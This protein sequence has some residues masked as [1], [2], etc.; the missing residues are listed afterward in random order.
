M[1]DLYSV[2]PL[3][4]DVLARAAQ[5]TG[6]LVVVEDH[7]PEGGIGEAVLSALAAQ[8]LAPAFTHLAVRN[9]PGS[10]TTSELLDA[11]GISRTRIIRTA[12]DLVGR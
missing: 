8:R 10:G 12:H 3:D 2:K 11:A 7:H 5:E 1:V 6:A 4:L 9:L